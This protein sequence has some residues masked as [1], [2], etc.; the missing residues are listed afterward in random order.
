MLALAVVIVVLMA[1]PSFA[2]IHVR[3]P[4]DDCGGSGPDNP[5][6]FAGITSQARPGNLPP[7]GDDGAHDQAPDDF[8]PAPI[9]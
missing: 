7:L 6:A 1:V 5:T 4:G 2:F 8:C 3:V 9:R